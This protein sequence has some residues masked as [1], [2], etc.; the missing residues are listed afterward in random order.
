[1]IF[2]HAVG[3]YKLLKALAI[4]EGHQSNIGGEGGDVMWSVRPFNFIWHFVGI[5]LIYVS[6]SFVLMVRC[7]LRI[8]SLNLF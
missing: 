3:G 6:F 4:E 2:V 5:S 7:F 8:V 1:M